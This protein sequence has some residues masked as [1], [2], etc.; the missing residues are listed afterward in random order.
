LSK[1]LSAGQGGKL[2]LW[3]KS[4]KLLAKHFQISQAFLAAAHFIHGFHHF[5]HVFKLLQQ[6]VYLLN[7]STA[8]IGNPFSPAAIDEFVRIPFFKG[9]RFDDGLNRLE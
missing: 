9:H 2:M 8:A 6:V 7:G 1:T 3:A 5:T 4:G